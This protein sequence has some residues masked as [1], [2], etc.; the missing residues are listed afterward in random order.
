MLSFAPMYEEDPHGTTACVAGAKFDKGKPRVD[1]VLD[2]FPLALLEVAKV[3]TFGAGKYSEHGWLS[4]PDGVKRYTAAM[5][6][7]RLQGACTDF[8][9]QSE[10]LHA[11]HLAWNAL[12]RLELMLRA[13]MEAENDD[14]GA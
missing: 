14:A 8:D 11:A 9:D 3:S 12:A 2:G 7:H 6:R 10:L 5:D 13:D 1:L 4:V